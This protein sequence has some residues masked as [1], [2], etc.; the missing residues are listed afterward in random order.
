M[1]QL[2][3]IGVETLIGSIER[4][5]EIPDEVIDEMCAAAADIAVTAY[6]AAVPVDSGQ[7]RDS[8]KKLKRK[9]KQTG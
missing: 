5:A 1:A 7:L 2:E 8:I 6:K 3:Q 4:L 9:N